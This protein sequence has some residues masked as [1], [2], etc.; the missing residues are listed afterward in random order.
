MMELCI[1]HSG[2]CLHPCDQCTFYVRSTGDCAKPTRGLCPECE[3][4]GLNPNK[5]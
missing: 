3:N 1:Y 5:Q 4:C 2:N